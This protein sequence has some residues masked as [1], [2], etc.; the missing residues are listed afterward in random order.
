MCNLCVR[1]RI[2]PVSRG[3]LAFARPVRE[4]RVVSA[5]KIA[6]SCSLS[7]K[8]C[9]LLRRVCLVYWN[10]FLCQKTSVGSQCKEVGSWFVR[11]CWIF[12]GPCMFLVVNL[13]SQRASR[14]CIPPSLSI[15]GCRPL[16]LVSVQYISLLDSYN[17]QTTQSFQ[18][19][20]FSAIPFGSSIG[21]C[22]PCL[23]VAVQYTS[24]PDSYSLQTVKSFQWLE[25]SAIPS[26]SSIGSC[27][28]LLLVA[29]QWSC[30]S[31]LLVL[32]LGVVGQ[33]VLIPG[34]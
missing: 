29:G 8:M 11:G 31:C 33:L 15:G 24:L 5:T 19:L 10:L 6:F 32:V 18:W 27:R 20:E 2:I 1:G 17:L 25:F 9:G 34:P 16:L 21:G 26:G 30:R 4:R 7:G 14:C 22:R 28:S 13:P 12:A 23:L 3:Y